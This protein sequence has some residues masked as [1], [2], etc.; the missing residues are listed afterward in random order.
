MENQWE[1]FG[2]H[3]EESELQK[4][5][6]RGRWFFCQISGR[7][8]IG[9]TTLVNRLLERTKAKKIFYVQIPDSDPSGVLKSVNDALEDLGVPGDRFPAPGDLQQFAKLVGKM[10][11]SDYFVVLDEFQYFHRKALYPFCS[12]L[13][14]EV[15]RLINDKTAAGGLFV[16]GSIHTEMMAVLE[17]RRSPLFNRVT[18]RLVI[19]HL[20]FSDLKELW[21][22]YD[23]SDPFHQLFLWSLFEG[24]PKF[25][26]DCFEQGVLGRMPQY[27]EKLLEEIFFKGSSPLRTEADNWFLN[28]FRGRYE[29]LLKIIA[30][31]NGCSHSRIMEEYA[32]IRNNGEISQIGGYLHVLESKFRIV[33]RQL[34]VFGSKGTSRKARYYIVDNFLLSWL[35]AI[36]RQVKA[37]R[38][39]PMEICVKTCADRLQTIEGIAF[40]KLIRF[41][42]EELSRKGDPR[43]QL[44]SQVSAYWNKPEDV[45]KNIEID[46]LMV[47]EEKRILRIATAKRS[48]SRLIEDAGNFERHIN[49]FLG[50]KEGRRYADYKIIKTAFAPRCSPR[51][52]EKMSGLGFETFGFDE[53]L[54]KL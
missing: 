1:F 19:N 50:T 7:R 8:R 28:E 40:Q 43:F 38:V 34:P 20:A 37:A 46:H 10:T 33:E 24:V 26:R 39:R 48:D 17:D 32:K 36:E 54:R 4:I 14:A 41:I 2:R 23:I 52:K 5:A 42:V 35:G 51:V 25:Y 9:K 18:D 29:S 30:A 16:L 22:S 3:T 21:L 45:L 13:Q 15:D 53:L 47:N 11:E 27:R 31:N 12:Y 6:A 44:T 49:A